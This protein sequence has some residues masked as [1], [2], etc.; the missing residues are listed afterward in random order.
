MR[1]LTRDRS[2]WE[3]IDLNNNPSCLTLD[4]MHGGLVER[5]NL[6]PLDPVRGYLAV[7]ESMA[8]TIRSGRADAAGSKI[9]NDLTNT[10]LT[11]TANQI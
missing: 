3:D 2:I 9:N 10:V 7:W 4:T 11:I 8:I 6:R 1:T 5:A